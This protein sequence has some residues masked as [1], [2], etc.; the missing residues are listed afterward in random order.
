MSTSKSRRSEVGPKVLRIGIVQRGKII[1]EREL[2]RRET[3]S[4]GTDERATFT[5]V[6]GA[7]PKK[8]DLFE[9]D[10]HNYFL[11]FEPPMDGR[12]QLGGQKAALDFNR[13]RQQGQVTRK[14]G[15]EAVPLDDSSRGKVVIGDVTVLF[16]FKAPAAAPVKPVLPADIR[17]TLLQN[18]D[19]QFATI[20]VFVATFQIGLVAYAR[21]LP[22]VEPTSIEQVDKLYQRMIMPDRQPQ[23]PK[24]PAPVPEDE[25]EKAEKGKEKAPAKKKKAPAKKKAPT[26]SSEASAKAKKD[27]LKKQVAGKGLLKVLGATRQG[28]N[29]ALGDVFSEGTDSIG[30][31]G[32]AFDGIQGV[33][34]AGEGSAGTRGRGSGKGV[35]IGDLETEGGGNVRAGTKSEAKVSGTAQVEAPAVDGELSQAAINRVLNR[36]KKALRDCY[37]RALKRDRA[38]K[39]KIVISFEILETGR[40][41][42][43][44]IDDRMGSN[45]VASC[46]KKRV[47]YWRF[48]RP[49]GG[50]VFVDLPIVFQP[51]S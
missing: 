50:S 9:Y 42:E 16:Q 32:K 20:F 34:V 33:D 15:V 27:A 26:K 45:T 13:L 47:R 37:E 31:L 19:V 10:G 22:Y 43:I 24:P 25:T 17:G 46:I 12:I 2:K 14:S 51:S 21:S 11:R 6:S 23:P 38:L 4:V 30:D 35:G 41:A 29:D 40:T 39:G 3:V 1:D 44:S 7:M 8:F 5:A 18:I 28:G 48:P 49:A 36:Q